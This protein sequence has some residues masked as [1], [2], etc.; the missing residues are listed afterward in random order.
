ML[1]ITRA[2]ENVDR[3][4]DAEYTDYTYDG[5][6]FIVSKGVR[7]VGIYNLDHVVSIILKE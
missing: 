4:S 5:R 7:T 1:E 6:L 2:N 3:W